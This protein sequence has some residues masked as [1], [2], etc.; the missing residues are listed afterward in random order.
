[1]FSEFCE[2]FKSKHLSKFEDRRRRVD[3]DCTLLFARLVTPTRKYFACEST[4]SSISFERTC[5]HSLFV[6]LVTK[7]MPVDLNLLSGT[8]LLME[9]QK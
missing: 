6:F 3:R 4:D 7:D 5:Y 9:W 8:Q 2:E 1:M